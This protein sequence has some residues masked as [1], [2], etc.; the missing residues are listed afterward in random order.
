MDVD[1]QAIQGGSFYGD[2]IYEQIKTYVKIGNADSSGYAYSHGGS[3][4]ASAG[5]CS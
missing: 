4:Y 2:E 1:V 3:R 5:F